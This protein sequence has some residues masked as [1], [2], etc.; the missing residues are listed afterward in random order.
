MAR[1]RRSDQQRKPARLSLTPLPV[2]VPPFFC[3]ACGYRGVA[4][5]IALRWFDANGA[6]WVSD[7]GHVTTGCSRA[8]RALW[9]RADGAIALDLFRAEER[10]LGRPPWLLLDRETARLYVGGP[11]DVWPLI[12]AQHPRRCGD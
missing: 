8:L 10:A 3:E 5:Y 1:A 11:A 9:R 12:D 4:R 6:L 7:D 2:T